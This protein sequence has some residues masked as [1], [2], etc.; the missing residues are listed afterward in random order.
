MNHMIWWSRFSEQ[1]IRPGT[2]C[3]TLNGGLHS[4]APFVPIHFVGCDCAQCGNVYV[5]TYMCKHW[6]HYSPMPVPGALRYRPYLSRCCRQFGRRRLARTPSPPLDNTSS[7][8]MRRVLKHTTNKHTRCVAFTC[9]NSHPFLRWGA[10]SGRTPVAGRMAINQNRSR[11][12]QYINAAV[13]WEITMLHVHRFVVCFGFDK[14]LN[15]PKYISIMGVLKC[16]I[17]FSITINKNKLNRMFSLIKLVS[18][19]ALISS[20]GFSSVFGSVFNVIYI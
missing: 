3:P 19:N 11:Q 17:L 13:A 20:F 6:K 12:L 16:S 5:Y 4:H 1:L 8:S 9:T 18:I 10:N 14:Y 2:A 7:E 15:L